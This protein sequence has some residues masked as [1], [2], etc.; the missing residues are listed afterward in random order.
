MHW[1]ERLPWPGLERRETFHANGQRDI[2]LP[3]RVNIVITVGDGNDWVPPGEN[4]ESR[5][6]PTFF[7]GSSGRACEWRPSGLS[8][9]IAQPATD[10]PLRLL[11]SQSESMT[12]LV[13]GLVRDS[14]ASGTALEFHTQEETVDLGSSTTEVTSTSFVEILAIE[15]P[16]S[17][18]AE[19]RVFDNVNGNVIA[20]I[21][22]WDTT[23]QFKKISTPL[24]V[25]AGTALPIRYYA[26]P[27]MLTSIDQSVE[28]AIP[29]DFL[30][31]RAA[32]DLHFIENMPDAAQLSW[33]K[34]EEVLTN[35]IN[36][37]RSFG[38]RDATAVP[39]GDYLNWGDWDLPI[40]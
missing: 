22:P 2:V 17:T 29:N 1:A 35:A 10:S 25:P 31:W 32:G 26:Y 19:L 11:S 7:S 20:R 40:Y 21:K 39:D 33:A 5:W 9:V 38:Q 23:A 6:G 8:P 28:T 27:Q 37:R 36:A 13:R 16:H 3:D 30:V 12:V 34:A 18:T 24:V 15:K 4:F 14:T